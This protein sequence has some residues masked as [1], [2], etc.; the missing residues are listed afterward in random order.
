MSIHWEVANPSVL[1][2]LMEFYCAVRNKAYEQNQ[3]KK[4]YDDNNVN[5]KNHNWN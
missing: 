5:V 1:Q 4:M 2:E 3:E